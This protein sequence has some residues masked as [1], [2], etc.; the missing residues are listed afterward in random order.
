MQLESLT[1]LKTFLNACTIGSV[2][3]FAK[4]HRANNEVININGTKTAFETTGTDF[5]CFII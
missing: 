4:P 5:E 1:T 2:T 3:A